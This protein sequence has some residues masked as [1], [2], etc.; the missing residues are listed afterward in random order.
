GM[1]ASRRALLWRAAPGTGGRV[2]L[3]NARRAR[4]LRTRRFLEFLVAREPS[5]IVFVAGDPLALLLARRA[6][7][8][9]QGVRRLRS[10]T[11]AAALAELAAAASAG[12]LVW[13]G[14]NYPRVGAPPTSPP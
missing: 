8:K 4:P 9:R 7:F 11:A 13:G 2:V 6:G 10:R 12:G 1:A 3:L 5:P 14:R